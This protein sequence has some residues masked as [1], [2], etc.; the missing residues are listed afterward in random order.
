[1]DGSGTGRK[2]LKHRLA[3]ILSVFS[4]RSGGRKRRDEEA[5]PPPLALPS[6]ARIG[7]A[8]AKKI[9]AQ[10]HDRRLSVSA[11]RTVPMIRITIDCAGRR[12]V[13]AADPSLLA[14][15][16]A[17]AKKLETSE[18]EGRKCPPSSPF[19]V[20]PLPPLP[21]W[22]ERP[23]GNRRLS[24]HSSRR[25]LSS[26]SSDDEY[27][28]DSRNLF[29]SRSFSSDSSDFY[30][31]PRKNNGA[32][33]RASVS[34]PCRAP[35]AGARRGASQSCRYSFELPRGSTASNATD[36]GF[37][38]VKRSADPYEDFRK[39][40]EEMIAEWPEGGDGLEGEH[41]AE[42]LLETYL[43]LNSP[44]HYPA[45]LAAFADVRETLCP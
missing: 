9:G 31:C 4:R 5:A 33:A 26:S 42:G 36:G 19:A 8:G 22:K 23:S 20:A 27:D 16:D 25:L 41:D 11:R 14:P 43:V 44:R 18:W 10:Q 34:G 32:K 39:S 2:K 45:I 29:S 17:D 13:D 15:L 1:M 40:M 7:T 35:P 24:T 6:Y 3:A 38:V 21:R 37:A 30:N 12:S 28:E